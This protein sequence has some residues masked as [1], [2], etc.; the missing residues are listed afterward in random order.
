MMAEPK[1][2]LIVA[3]LVAAMAGPAFA[4][5]DSTAL[6]PMQ[7]SGPS[8][9]QEQAQTANLNRDI[10]EANSTADQHYADQKKQYDAARSA[11]DAALA[12]YQDAQRQYEA[13]KAQ[14]DREQQDYQDKL[15]AYQAATAKKGD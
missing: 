4:Q 11:N 7:Q 12:Q 13:Q 8:T 10:S 5:N 9:P 6:P 3:A 15:K 2:C 1:S 14:N